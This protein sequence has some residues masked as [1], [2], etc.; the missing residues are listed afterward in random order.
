MHMKLSQ[1][2]ISAFEQVKATIA[3]LS[4]EYDEVCKKITATEKRLSD[5][6]LLPVPVADLKAAILDFVDASGK[7]YLDEYVK[8]AIASFATHGMAGGG[9][10]AEVMGKPLSYKLLELSV[11][12]SSGALSRSQ[13]LTYLEK[14]HFND[15]VLYA[16]FG[17]LVKAG[18]AAVMDTMTDADFGYAQLKPS[19]IGTD[20]ATRRVDI[21]AA[22]DQL[23]ELRASKIAL[24]GS[25]RQVGVTVGG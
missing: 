22:Q 24:A 2:D 3:A 23:S 20:R 1:Q 17:G 7:G 13:L 8:P 11:I 21:Q 15:M 5:L 16:F 9:L 6:P 10:N 4:A 25:L 19:Q 18:L 14:S 12:P